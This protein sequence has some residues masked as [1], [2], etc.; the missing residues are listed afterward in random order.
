MDSFGFLAGIALIMFVLFSSIDKENETKQSH[1]LDMAKIGMMKC[2]DCR[3]LMEK[4]N[5]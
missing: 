2:T 3:S 5:E 1:E 4:G